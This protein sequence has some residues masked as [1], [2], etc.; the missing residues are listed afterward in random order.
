MT[1]TLTRRLTKEL[2]KLSQCWAMIHRTVMPSDKLNLYVRSLRRCDRL[3]TAIKNL[4]TAE[5]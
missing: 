3:Q 5:L 4:E 2:I 1:A